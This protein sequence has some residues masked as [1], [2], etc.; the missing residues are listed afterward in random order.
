MDAG[1]DVSDADSR[2]ELTVAKADDEVLEIV[3]PYGGF[4]VEDDDADAD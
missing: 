4:V 1:Y 2:F 3:R